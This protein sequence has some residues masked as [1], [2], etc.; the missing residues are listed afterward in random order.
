M[1]SVQ[2]ATFANRGGNKQLYVTPGSLIYLFVY[3]AK[4]LYFCGFIINPGLF[5]RSVLIK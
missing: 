4:K 3:F 5:E 1:L 2:V